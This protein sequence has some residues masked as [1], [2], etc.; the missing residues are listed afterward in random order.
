MLRIGRS[1]KQNPMARRPAPIFGRLK[2]DHAA[3]RP[4]LNSRSSPFRSSSFCLRPWRPSLPLRRTGH[5]RRDGHRRASDPNRT[6]HLQPGQIDGQ[7]PN[8]VSGCGLQRD[9]GDEL[10]APSE[11]E[12][13]SKL[14][15]D[16]RTVSSYNNLPP[17]L[18]RTGG[19][20]PISIRP[21]STSPRAGRAPSTWFGS[22]IAGRS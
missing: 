7:D 11:A 9:C 22:I 1:S 13:P 15:I 4:R 12:T 20:D 2:K 21:A 6:D 17:T 19:A 16:V 8:R 14:F 18:P 10:L 3:A 5:Q